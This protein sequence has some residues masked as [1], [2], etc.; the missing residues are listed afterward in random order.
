MRKPLLSS[1]YFLPESDM[2][3][4]W[5]LLTY[6][7]SNILEIDWRRTT[8]ASEVYLLLIKQSCPYIHSCVLPGRLCFHA[9]T[10]C[11]LINS[12]V[13]ASSSVRSHRK[14]MLPE[15]LSGSI[16]KLYPMIFASKI[17]FANFPPTSLVCQN[18]QNRNPFV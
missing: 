9:N 8:T 2:L 15:I 17:D 14:W 13:C 7:T 4:V 1:I 10:E 6:F 5:P 18:S 11:T 12:A 3:P 16:C